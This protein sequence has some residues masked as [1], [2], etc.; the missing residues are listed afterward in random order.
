MEPRSASRPEWRL[1]RLS[2]EPPL[3]I[4]RGPSVEQSRPRRH[5]ASGP[6]RTTKPA[7]GVRRPHVLRTHPEADQACW[8]AA[9]AREALQQA[10]LP[11]QAQRARGAQDAA[12]DPV[13]QDTLQ[14][15]GCP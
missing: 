10:Q 9:Q 3:S 6:S 2:M 5:T 7:E 12:D 1:P 15:L 14:A 8:D 4:R 13:L 11:G